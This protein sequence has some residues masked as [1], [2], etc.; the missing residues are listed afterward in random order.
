VVYAL[1]AAGQLGIA[2]V[3]LATRI[4]GEAQ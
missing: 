2:Q 3:Q 1:D 4:S